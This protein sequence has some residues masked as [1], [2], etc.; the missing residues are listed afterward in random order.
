MSDTN[1]AERHVNCKDRMDSH[2]RDIR[3]KLQSKT[4]YWITAFIII[5]LSGS[6]AYTHKVEAK[7]YENEK[8]IQQIVT[9]EDMEK[10]QKALVDAIK[11]ISH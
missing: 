6:Y 3:T 2:A 4:F 10:M 11:E 1:C 9:K 7:T 8:E 5:S